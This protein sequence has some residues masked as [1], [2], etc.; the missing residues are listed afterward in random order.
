MDPT[1]FAVWRFRNAEGVMK[2]VVSYNTTECVMNVNGT[3]LKLNYKPDVENVVVS[4][5]DDPFKAPIT[6][7]FK[8]FVTTMT[9]LG[10]YELR[11]REERHSCSYGPTKP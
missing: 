7:P 10:F 1:Q 4:Y 11:P 3:R 9:D 8:D 5:M 6:I 2:Y